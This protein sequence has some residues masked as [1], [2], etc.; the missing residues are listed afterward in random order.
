[1]SAA[2]D[3]AP[4]AGRPCPANVADVR[5]L[6]SDSIG[7]SKAGR[8]GWVVLTRRI[9]DGQG[10]KNGMNKGSHPANRQTGV[11]AV[12]GRPLVIC[13]DINEGL[14]TSTVYRQAPRRRNVTN[15]SECKSLDENQHFSELDSMLL[16]LSVVKPL[17]YP[18]LT[19]KRCLHGCSLQQ[20]D[21]HEARNAII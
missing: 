8:G 17:K 19:L 2:G 13:Q 15:P 3:N 18:L 21:I 4:G 16:V 5:S 9:Q 6:P 7:K 14:T 10:D 11:K 12:R 20:R 1:M